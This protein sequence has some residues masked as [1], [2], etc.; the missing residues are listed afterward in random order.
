MGRFHVVLG[1]AKPN[2]GP[3][4]VVLGHTKPNMGPFHVALGILNQIW[5]VSMLF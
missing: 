1:N 4:H 2:M 5:D 3:F